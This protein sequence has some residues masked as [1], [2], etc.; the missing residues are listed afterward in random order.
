[1]SQ[2][3]SKW[4]KPIPFID[5]AAQRQR[6]GSSIE[7]AMARVVEHGQFIMGP[8]IRELEQQLAAFCG[9]KHA[10]TCSSG[11][12]ALALV[13]MGLG[14]RPGQAVICPSFTFCA[15]AE[16]VAW[17]GATP[18]FCDV[19]PSAFNICP[20][21]MQNAI[22]K[23]RND[24]L[25]PVG[26]IP[27]DLFGAPADY[28]SIIDITDNEG[29]WILADAA[30]SFGATYKGRSIG[31]IGKATAT[32]F[33]PAKP[34]GCFGDGGAVLTDDEELAD[35]MRSIRVHGQGAHKYDNVRIGMAARMDTIQAAVL[36]EKLKVFPEEIEARQEVANR[37]DVQLNGS[38]E[39]PEIASECVSVWAQYTVKVNP[40]LRDAIQSEL[41]AKGIPTQVYYPLPLHL[42]KAYASCPRAALGLSASETLSNSVLSL[43]MHPYLEAEVQDFISASLVAAISN[44]RG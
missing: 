30:Q 32:S 6:I 21:S 23:A 4:T 31:T 41:K 28:D 37:Y 9:A 24:G 22:E 40:G 10:L 16:V 26:V 43:P 11:T 27:V 13:I 19:D 18:V 1:M 8:E 5:L 14:V 33:F 15:T 34:L 17:A 3:A 38:C 44:C 12:D 25:E 35:R 20:R 2:Q 39:V 29:M 7:A 42:Q 36:I